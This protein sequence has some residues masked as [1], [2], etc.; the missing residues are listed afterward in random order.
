MK[1]RGLN[2]ILGII[3]VAAMVAVTYISQYYSPQL[4][5]F[6]GFITG[7]LV[8]LIVFFWILGRVGA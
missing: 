6:F 5:V 2:Y 3:I 7:Y 8:A 1:I 4:V